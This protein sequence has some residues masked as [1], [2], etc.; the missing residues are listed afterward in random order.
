MEYISCKVLTLFCC[1]DKQICL[2]VEQESEWKNEN[3]TLF[4]FVDS[5]IYISCVSSG[6]LVGG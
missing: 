5:F 2:T 3:R 4:F 1:C 6:S